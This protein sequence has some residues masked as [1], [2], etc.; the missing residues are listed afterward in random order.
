VIYPGLSTG[1]EF[2]MKQMIIHR[3][4]K[5][6]D[7]NSITKG[8]FISGNLSWYHHPYFHDNI[9]LSVEWVMRRTKSGG[10]VSEFS[11]GPG[12]SRTFM[13]GTTYSVNDNGSI[14]IIKR[15]GY[16]YALITVGGGFGYDFSVKKQL[17]FS[18]LAKINL[19]SMFPFNSTIY[20]RPVLEIGIRF[21]PALIF[22]RINKEKLSS[23]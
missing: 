16:S 6:A 17:P 9:Y 5:Q 19:I 11:S 13:A 1:I 8:R 23:K 18:T 21:K 22:N 14:S 2:S 7:D 20:F 10:F 3:L 12:Y 15:A 4:K